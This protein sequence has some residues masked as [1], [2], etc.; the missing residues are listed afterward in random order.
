MYSRRLFAGLLLIALSAFA[1]TDFAGEPFARLSAFMRTPAPYYVG[2]PMVILPT[3]NSPTQ[4]HH[5]SSNQSPGPRA[6]PYGYFGAQTRTYYA[7]HTACFNKYSQT[8]FG[9]GY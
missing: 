1:T 6:Y 4:T 2:N 7:S 8:T 9:W 5:F 3:T